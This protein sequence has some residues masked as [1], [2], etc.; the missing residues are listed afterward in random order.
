MT[1]SRDVHAG[2][3]TAALR[4]RIFGFGRFIGVVSVI[5][6][7]LFAVQSRTVAQLAATRPL[8]SDGGIQRLR[9]PTL[10]RMRDVEW[11]KG[12]PHCVRNG[13]YSIRLACPGPATTRA[14][15]ASINLA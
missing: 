1:A 12:E 6:R 7:V 8:L 10:A 9:H 15:G 14:N 11:R 13:R 4:A 2:L 3:G 5:L